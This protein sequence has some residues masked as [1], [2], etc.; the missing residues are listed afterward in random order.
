MMDYICSLKRI[1]KDKCGS[2][3]SKA[4]TSVNLEDRARDK[5]KTLSGGMVRRAGIAQALLGNTKVL[6][7]DEPTAGLDPNERVRFKN[8]ISEVK[9]DKTILISTHI[10][11]DIDACCDNVIVVDN[12]EILY[13]GSCDGLRNM[14]LNKVYLLNDT[15]AAEIEGEK[16]T[17]R[18]NEIDGKI[19]HRILTNKKQTYESEKP[20]LEDGYMCLIKGLG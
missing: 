18:I 10:V 11:E 20:N 8:T 4:L 7:L 6:L 16:F 13:N 3:I 12:G 15:D 19:Y 17:L 2:E 1:A 5:G 9:T 14:A